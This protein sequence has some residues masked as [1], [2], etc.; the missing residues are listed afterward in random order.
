MD[1]LAEMERHPDRPWTVRDRMLQEA[2]WRSK[3]TPWAEWKAAALNW[4]IQGQ[5]VTGKP[6]RITA[7]TVRHGETRR[8]DFRKENVR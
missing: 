2:R 8:N 7:A 3:P 6:G 4:L 5:G 1:V